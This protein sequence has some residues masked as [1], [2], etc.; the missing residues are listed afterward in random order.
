[1]DCDTPRYDRRKDALE[2]KIKQSTR[3][4]K[5]PGVTDEGKRH[6]E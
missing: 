5:S 1:M 3:Q 2:R 6:L 4:L